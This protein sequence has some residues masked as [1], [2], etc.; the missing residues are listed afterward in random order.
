M[1]AFSPSDLLPPPGTPGW[2]GGF[3]R[4]T[5][6]TFSFASEGARL[7]AGQQSLLRQA[8]AAWQAAAGVTFVEVPWSV[9][10]LVAGMGAPGDTLVLPAA[11]TLRD[12]LK[13]AGAALGLIPDAP[14]ATLAATVMAAEP[15][16]AT[17]LGWADAEA[18]PALFGSRAEAT[19]QGV[20][21]RYDASL[22]MVRGDLF[23]FEDRTVFGANQGTALFGDIGNDLLVG[24]A[25]D[26]LFMGGP[27]HNA[28]RGGA[29]RDVVATD[30]LR[31]EVTL[32]HPFQRMSTEWGTDQWDEV[33]FLRLRDGG[34]ALHSHEHAALVERLYQALLL[35]A[36]DPTGLTTWTDF[37]EAGGSGEE[38]I[39]RIT[40][41]DEYLERF[42]RPDE[43]AR[44]RGLA[45]L[46]PVPA[47]TLDAPLW[48]PEAEAVLAVRFHLL[49]AGMAPDR[50]RFDTW[51]A[52]LRAAPDH[53]AAAQDFLDAHPGHAFAD[54]QALLAAAWS[55]AVIRATAPWVDEGVVLARDWLF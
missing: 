39:R 29:G 12:A 9:A 30:F 49:V 32:D 26:D 27:G 55:P 4:P 17:G 2:T 42:G 35:R 41:S 43:A 50:A 21:W 33:E 14:G 28:F 13:A 40:W 37:L 24:G 48:V 22:D 6:L 54:G 5:V 46:E 11:P 44:A 1:F 23:A 10:D 20:R 38:L 34:F 8:L 19:A 15:G 18:I 47:A 52:A 16:A 3:A 25:G 31:A 36:A 45:A 53:A 51:H 7:D